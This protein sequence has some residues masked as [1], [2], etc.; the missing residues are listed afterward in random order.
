M[1]PTIGSLELYSKYIGVTNHSF[2]IKEFQGGWRALAFT[3]FRGGGTRAR[4]RSRL[5]TV[6][7]VQRCCLCHH[8]TPNGGGDDPEANNL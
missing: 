2:S 7:V 5:L 6:V 8:R 1:Q 4:L 3:C